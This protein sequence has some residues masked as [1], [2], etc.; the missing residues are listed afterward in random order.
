[1]DYTN[2]GEIVVVVVVVV[3]IVVVLDVPCTTS[4]TR[5]APS[6]RKPQPA[7]TSATILNGFL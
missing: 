7:K 2:P 3:L 5:P 4:S 1:M 6:W